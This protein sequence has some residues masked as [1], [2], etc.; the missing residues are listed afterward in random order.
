MR[1]RIGVLTSGGDCPGLN[2]AI[3]SLC[4][5]AAS[6]HVEVLGIR[7]GWEGLL[8]DDI[9]ILRPHDV[10]DISPRGGTILGTSRINPL[11]HDWMIDRLRRNGRKHKVGAL[12]VIGGDG[13]LSAANELWTGHGVPLVG[14]PKTIDNDLNGTDVTFGFATAIHVITESIDRLRTT[15]SSHRRIMVIEVMGRHSGWLAAYGGVAGAADLILVP[16]VPFRISDVC[17][18]LVQRHSMG[19]TFS[20]VVVAEDAHP[21]QDENF[22]SDRTISRIYQHERLGGIGAALAKEI[23]K[24]TDISTRTTNLGYVQRGGA[25][26]AMDRVLA[27]LFGFKAYEMV[28]NKR[29]G[30]MAA[31]KGNEIVDVPLSEVVGESKQLPPNLLECLRFLNSTT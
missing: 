22:L 15:A 7:N 8:Q 3:R 2:A 5:R 1:R 17:K 23:E 31:L 25:P 21:H 6:D 11:E 30:H 9:A 27:T 29:W 24:R 20:L 14:L 4:L 19:F 16:E 13:S 28:Q 10:A 18:R 26:T 12:I